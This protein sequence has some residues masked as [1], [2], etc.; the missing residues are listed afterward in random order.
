MLSACINSAAFGTSQRCEKIAAGLAAKYEKLLPYLAENVSDQ[1][2][3]ASVGIE[4]G[5][6]YLEKFIQLPFLVPQPAQKEIDK[7]MDSLGSAAQEQNL[8]GA[9]RERSRPRICC[10]TVG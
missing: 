3:T 6:T 1:P 8:P 10:A 9:P 4:F 7:L 2:N 5:Y